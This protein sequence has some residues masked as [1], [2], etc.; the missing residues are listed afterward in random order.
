MH[1]GL[2]AVKMDKLMRAVA[3]LTLTL[4]STISLG[5]TSSICCAGHG[6]Q[7]TRLSA[8]LKGALG[9]AHTGVDAAP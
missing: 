7:E 2:A 9:R 1:H 6:E 8:L 5:G 3:P 4:A